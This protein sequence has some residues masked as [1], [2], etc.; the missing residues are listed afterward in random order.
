MPTIS[1]FYGIAIRMFLADHSPPH[2]HAIYG[3]FEATFSI[4]TGKLLKGTFPKTATK[5]VKEWTDLNRSALVEDWNLAQQNKL[6]NP[7]GG[8]D[9]E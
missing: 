1:V 2:F 4:E 9:A 7:I 6:P 8:L 3:E 5:L